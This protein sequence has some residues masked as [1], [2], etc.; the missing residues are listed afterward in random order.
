MVASAADEQNSWLCSADVFVN[1]L[2]FMLMVIPL[3]N[4]L[5]TSHPPAGNRATKGILLA[6]TA[7]S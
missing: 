1:A 6:F 5:L 3:L 7:P 4:L 2:A